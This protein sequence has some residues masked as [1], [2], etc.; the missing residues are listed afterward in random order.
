MT[1]KQIQEKIETVKQVVIDALLA[2]FGIMLF[3]A[4]VVHAA[5]VFYH[6]A[7]GK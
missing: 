6:W 4:V 2:I 7:F 5:V 3:S 1:G